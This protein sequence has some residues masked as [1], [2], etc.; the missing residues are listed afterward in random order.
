MSKSVSLFGVIHGDP[1]VRPFKVIIDNASDISDLKKAI[2]G[3]MPCYFKH[4]DVARLKLWRWNKKCKEVMDVDLNDRDILS[5]METIDEVFRSDPPQKGYVH[6]VVKAPA[7]ISSDDK[8]LEIFLSRVTT[9][10]YKR[11]LA[12]LDL[13]T[14]KATPEIV[15][16][17]MDVPEF[18]W[19]PDETEPAHHSKYMKWL[20]DYID[21]PEDW[22]FYNAS[23]E[24]DLLDTT[25][26]DRTLILKGTTDVVIADSDYVKLF[27]TASGVRVAIGMKRVVQQNDHR[28]AIL[29]L[30]AANCHSNYPVL[31]LLTDLGK[32][33]HF[34]WMTLHGIHECWL[35][36]PYAIAFIESYLRGEKE[37]ACTMRDYFRAHTAE[38]ETDI[39]AAYAQCPFRGLPL[40]P[41]TRTP[42]LLKRLSTA[43][44]MH[45]GLRDV[46]HALNTYLK[47]EIQHQFISP[48]TEAV[49]DPITDIENALLA[50][51][52][53]AEAYEPAAEAPQP[54]PLVT[55]HA[56]LS[57]IEGLLLFSL[58]SD[59]SANTTALQDALKCEKKRIEILEMERRQQHVQRRITE[60]LGTSG[61][62]SSSP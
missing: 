3:E 34:Y 28:Q 29:Q 15:P 53:P 19:D 41:L 44:L 49:E 22:Q 16:F 20:S 56:A 1:D 31:V 54:P 46:S 48:P 60:F 11:F 12:E 24:N 9:N 47:S 26:T 43:Q 32:T 62:S 25:L 39:S 2:M 10:A 7:N 21:I 55:P 35:D 40:T 5:E 59:P 17:F 4:T 18:K 57:Y 8:Q 42:H 13:H 27:D 51:Y 45:K 14:M 6:I 23:A 52:L 30:V 61:A 38:Q 58:Q 50:T 36:A 33:W 37:N